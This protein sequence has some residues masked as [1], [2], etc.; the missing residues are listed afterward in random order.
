MK[1]FILIF[2]FCALIAVAVVAFFLLSDTTPP[3]KLLDEQG[4]TV[5]LPKT[6]KIYLHFWGAWCK[7]CIAE[8]PELDR[9]AAR[10]PDITIYAIHVGKQSMTDIQSV[11]AH[12]QIKNLKIYQDPEGTLANHFRIHG[13]PSTLEVTSDFQ[14]VKRLTGP[15]QWQY[16]D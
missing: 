11:Y 1:N 5:I 16:Y 13:F 15:Q 9:Y 6:S 10:H 14:E 7:P 2:S 3:P 4:N 8:L 12:L